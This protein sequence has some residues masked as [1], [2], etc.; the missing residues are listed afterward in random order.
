MNNDLCRGLLN[1]TIKS[2]RDCNTEGV[3]ITY[4]NVGLEV[5]ADKSEP[6]VHVAA[7]CRTKSNYNN[8]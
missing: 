4:K 3:L 6:H 7:E 5:H 1:I 2:V 8:Q